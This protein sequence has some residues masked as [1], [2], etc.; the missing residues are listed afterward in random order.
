MGKGGG[1]INQ[2]LVRLSKQIWN[3]LISKQII[4]TAQHLPG[5]LNVETD[6]EFRNLKESNKCVLNRDIF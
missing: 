2:D 4:L 5:I 1:E 3:Y 6:F